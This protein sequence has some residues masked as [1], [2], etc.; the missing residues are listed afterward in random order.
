[1]A[2]SSR[3][4]ASVHS[5]IFPPSASI[6]LFRRLILTAHMSTDLVFVIRV[7]LDTRHLRFP[8]VL[9]HA[10]VDVGLMYDFGDQL[11][12]SVDQRG[13]RSGDFGA[14]DGV[15]GAIFNEEGEEGE[16]AADEEG[17]D[18]EVDGEEDGETTTHGCRGRVAK[19]TRGS[20]RTLSVAR[21]ARVTTARGGPGGGGGDEG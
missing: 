13:V 19:R 3:D 10:V 11:R 2:I 5:Y 16:D 6:D 17:D 4:L 7:Q 12:H 20:T 1:M 21:L 14:V 8:P 18:E 9:G 15:G